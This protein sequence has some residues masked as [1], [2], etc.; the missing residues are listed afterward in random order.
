MQSPI[1]TIIL[2]LRNASTFPLTGVE[3]GNHYDGVHLRARYN[4]TTVFPVR[5][6]AANPG[7]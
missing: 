5:L 2:D 7:C 3:I 1:D 4:W 6:M